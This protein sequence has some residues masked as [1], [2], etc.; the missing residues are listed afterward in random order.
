MTRPW[1]VP[2]RPRDDQAAGRGSTPLELLFDLSFVVAV[3]QIAAE[4]SHAV[5]DDHAGAGLR[6]YLMVFF[7][8]WWAWMNFTWFASAYDTDDVPY[9]LLTM[10][11]MSGVLLLAAGVPRAFESQDFSVIVVGYVVMRVAMCVQ[12]LRAARN[13]APRRAV[14]LRYAVGIGVLQLGWILQLAVPDGGWAMVT[15]LV[16]VVGE[17]SVP[18]FAETGNMTPW[19]PHH[20]A[21]RYGL[22]TIIVLGEC[23]LASTVAVEVALDEGG[24]TPELVL[25][26]GSGLVL[27]FGLWW[28][29]FLEPTGEGLSVRRHLSFVFGYGHYGVFATLA[30]V[31]AGLEVGVE[32]VAHHIAASPLLVAY[33]VAAP[34]ALYL[35]L[36]L[37][38]ITPLAGGSPVV[39]PGHLAGAA[40]VVALLPLTTAW[41]SATVSVAVIAAVTTALVAT[42]IARPRRAPLQ[43]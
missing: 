21:E 2:M 23:V 14:A 29:Y 3:A 11:Q 34:V 17:L 6:G 15:F 10:L 9:R 31:G 43:G 18:Y 12:W 33:A 1:R 40:G 35:L 5:A 25:L 4:L 20:I 37:V 30:A 26:S 36:L 38:I 39:A 13:D 8:I 22:F 27:L 41:W 32:A 16:L 28:L 7:A 24:V 19:H 42:T